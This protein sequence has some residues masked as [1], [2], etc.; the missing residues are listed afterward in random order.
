MSPRRHW[1]YRPTP[2]QHIEATPKPY[3]AFKHDITGDELHDISNI[4]RCRE[5]RL[6][7]SLYACISIAEGVPQISLAATQVYAIDGKTFCRSAGLSQKL[8]AA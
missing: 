3:I 4:L 1:H 7:M 8:L 2:R 6:L 5:G